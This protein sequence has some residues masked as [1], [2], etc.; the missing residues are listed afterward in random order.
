MVTKNITLKHTNSGTDS[1]IRPLV[2][3]KMSALMKYI[4]TAS[5]VRTEV[6]FEKVVSHKSGPV[7]RVEVNVFVDGR[8]FRSETTQ[9]TFEAALDVA[10]DEL[11]GEM[12]RA[13]DKR[14]S[15]MRRGARKFKEMLRFGK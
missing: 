6:E 14:I 13:G 12:Q 11:A 8:V 3:Q 7:C 2:E 1:S 4:G 10:K 15:V 9:A 5:D